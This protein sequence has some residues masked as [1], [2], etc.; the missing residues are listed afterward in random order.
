MECKQF[1]DNI[2]LCRDKIIG[3][4]VNRNVGSY[5]ED[6]FQTA[7]I[8]MWQNSSKFEPG[9]SFEGWAWTFTKNV[10]L[11]FFRSKKRSIV[12]YDRDEPVEQLYDGLITEDIIEDS[13]LE[14]LREVLGELD[15]REIE[16]L[17]CVYVKGESIKSFAKKKNLSHRTYLN[18]VSLLRKKIKAK[19]REKIAIKNL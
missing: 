5:A 3:R 7:V 11:N 18:K 8:K 4:L 6:I 9:T 16:L 15:K 13:R 17:Q 2:S 12:N 1:T 10:L 14:A 19:V